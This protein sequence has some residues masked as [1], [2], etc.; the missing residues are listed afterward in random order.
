MKI[1][2]ILFTYL[3][4]FL[5]SL[6]TLGLI[7]F[8]VFQRDLSNIV[9]STLDP[10]LNAEVKVQSLEATLFN[11]FPMGSVE[12]V[13]VRIG[14]TDTAK[15]ENAYEIGRVYL[16]FDYKDLL[17]GNFRVRHIIIRDADIKMVYRSDGS[18]NFEFW[19]STDSLSADTSQVE[20]LLDKVEVYNTNYIFY[21]QL[22][23]F[24]LQAKIHQGQFSLH[25]LSSET[26]MD[27]SADFDINDLRDGELQWIENKSLKSQ[28]G[29]SI[30]DLDKYTIQD[31]DLVVEGMKFKVDGTI[32]N[33]SPDLYTDIKIKSEY[34]RL[35]QLIS[36]SPGLLAGSLDDYDI[37]GAA[38][39]KAEIVG[40]WTATESAN[41][42]VGFGFREG[43]IEQKSSGLKLTELNLDGRYSNGSKNNNNTSYIHLKGLNGK[44]NTGK[45]T[46]DFYMENF[47]DPFLKFNLKANLDL[48]WLNNMFSLEDVEEVH[49]EIDADLTFE[50]LLADL[51][52]V[53][54]LS[55][56]KVEGDVTLNDIALKIKD[57][58]SPIDQIKGELSFQKPYLMVD[59]FKMKMGASDIALDGY[60]KNPLTFF[61]EKKLLLYGD[62]ICDTILVE[63]FLAETETNTQINGEGES[64]NSNFSEMVFANLN[65]QIDFL[66]YDD[67]KLNG[68]KGNVRFYNRQLFLNS[69]GF[70]T[71][72]GKVDITG[73][74]KANLFTGYTVDADITLDSIDINELFV[75]FDNFDQDALTN[76]H[77]LG[78]VSTRSSV[79]FRMDDSLELDVPTLYVDAPTKVIDGELV[80]FLP[81]M[82]L[83][84]FIKVG[85]FNHI[86]FDTLESHIF[87]QNEIIHIPKTDVHSNTFDMV[88][89]GTH[90]FENIVDYEVDLNLKKVFMDE[91]A[92]TDK[93]FS[94][95]A[96]E[97]KGG[98]TVYLLVKG[99]IDDPE[100]IYNTGA[101]GGVIGEGIKTQTEELK[102]AKEQEKRYKDLRRDSL[103]KVHRKNQRVRRRNSL[104][105]GWNELQNK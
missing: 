88:I 48:E 74:A 51:E 75:V 63:Q 26:F 5:M 68:V 25:T 82:K 36:I 100:I 33:S 50:G 29:F 42:N 39:F 80:E 6:G 67:F 12:L 2:K 41:F 72:G 61:S 101:L 76:E 92:I 102:K 57:L 34:S 87:I 89:S 4:V 35:E 85:N 83:A 40:Q 45:V 93:T 94:L 70:K 56:V 30:K 86:I 44:H 43:S 27:I 8:H 66:G 31:G 59:G 95:Y 71:L 7:L 65:T 79:S 28:L 104:K 23:G 16:L 52:K 84:G 90:D 91:N 21:N 37:N 38:Y 69:V 47:N 24:K 96:V 22:D 10:Y 58:N 14:D 73:M 32:D 105:E 81:M 20:L 55:E 60:F 53:E 54:R 64:D 13:N 19:K 97:P 103:L 77:I 49:G 15:T 3:F 18:T 99:P 62:L 9:L 11:T 78:R 98:I 1:V 17:S 46:G